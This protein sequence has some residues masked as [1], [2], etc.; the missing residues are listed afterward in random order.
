MSYLIPS[1]T[2]AAGDVGH[3]AD[4]NN[5]ADVVTA[6]G[7]A[8]LDLLMEP[9]GTTARTFPRWACTGASTTLVTQTLYVT[10]IALHQNT[11]VNNI[12]FCTK[13]TGTAGAT[14][15]HGWYVLLDS[16]LTVRAVTADQNGSTTFLASTNTPYTLATNSYT[17]AATGIYYAGI[18]LEC[19]TMCNLA[20]PGTPA[21]SLSSSAPLI[22]ATSSTGQTTP[23]ATSTVMG[24][25][26]VANGFL[27]YAATS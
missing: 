3:I 27:A 7:N 11:V 14:V 13:S 25:L 23:P 6:L 16:S 18:M 4:H 2:H 9:T 22:A 12:T 19:G 24:A 10:L 5:L 15:T 21:A 8:P 26:S 20:S 17:V 1:D